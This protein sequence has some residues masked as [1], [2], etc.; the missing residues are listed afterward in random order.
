M[1]ATDGRA[2][3]LDY[4]QSDPTKELT[5]RGNVLVLGSDERLERALELMIP[6]II[7]RGCRGATD[8]EGLAVDV[9]VIAG[10]QPIAELTEVRVHPNLYAKPVVLVAPGHRMSQQEWQAVGVWPVTS[11]GFDQIDV[12]TD[13]VAW[14]LSRIYHPASRGRAEATRAR[15][16]S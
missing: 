5:V 7:V 11:R 3:L 16:A 4:N 13:R 10:P 9:V 8:T 12:L 15:A 6:G 2:R 14:L 1:D